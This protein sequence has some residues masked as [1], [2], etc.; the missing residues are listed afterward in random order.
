MLCNTLSRS[1]NCEF[2]RAF[3]EVDEGESEK[4]GTKLGNFAP[5]FQPYSFRN[6]IWKL[7]MAV[8]K[9]MISRSKDYRSPQNARD[10]FLDPFLVEHV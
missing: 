5:R 4:I 7:H 3:I 6:S 10:S 2:V 8:A 1:Q 9:L